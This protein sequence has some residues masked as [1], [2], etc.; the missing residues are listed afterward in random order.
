MN[1]NKHEKY[2]PELVKYWIKEYQKAVNWWVTEFE[3]QYRDYGLQKVLYNEPSTYQMFFSGIDPLWQFYV[4][5]AEVFYN[6]TTARY[7]AT[8]HV[9]AIYEPTVNKYRFSDVNDKL[10]FAMQLQYNLKDG[11]PVDIKHI[12]CS[13]FGFYSD[14]YY[15][16][17]FIVDDPWC[18]IWFTLHSSSYNN[19]KSAKQMRRQA[20]KEIREQDRRRTYTSECLIENA[21]YAKELLEEDWKLEEP[22]CDG[23]DDSQFVIYDEGPNC[24][25]RYEIYQLCDGLVKYFQEGSEDVR[26]IYTVEIPQDI[27][28]KLQK[29]FDRQE[30]RG[31]R[32]PA[33]WHYQICTK[34]WYT[35]FIRRRA[36][37]E[38]E[39]QLECRELDING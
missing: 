22:F 25:P 9:Y 13:H 24:S 5:V 17:N 18:A 3:D 1:W 11:H 35:N 8:I 26:D 10:R 39:I 19:F 36:E 23:M 32:F 15:I 29:R 30:K 16:Q 37:F 14:L 31:A 34:E 6:Q 4:R 12:N 28:D 7:V 38:R 27:Q 20:R 21:Q 2:F 33:F